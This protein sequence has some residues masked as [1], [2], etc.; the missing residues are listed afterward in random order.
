MK[1]AFVLFLFLTVNTASANL[2]PECVA[3]NCNYCWY[4]GNWEGEIGDGPSEDP[5]GDGSGGS[6]PDVF[7]YSMNF[8]YWDD[9]YCCCEDCIPNCQIGVTAPFYRF[10]CQFGGVFECY[11]ELGE[12]KANPSEINCQAWCNPCA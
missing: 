12:C 4:D 8:C 11:P 5:N 6:G 9:Y 2:C 3:N 7:Y 1:G 10:L